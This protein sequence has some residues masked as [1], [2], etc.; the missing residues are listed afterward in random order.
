[1]ITRNIDTLYNYKQRKNNEIVIQAVRTESNKEEDRE[2]QIKA[3]W[4]N[5]TISIRDMVQGR[6]SETTE[7]FR[8]I[9]KQKRKPC[10][11]AFS[12]LIF[13][14]EGEAYACCPDISEQLYLGH[15]SMVGSIGE[16]FNSDA[17]KD[18]RKSL[19]NGIGFNKNPCKNCSSYE[20]YS[21]YKHGWRS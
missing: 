21:G 12:R 18:L 7:G 11:Q 14:H 16:I 15:I 5:A 2:G 9:D 4:P 19:K 8:S 3:R 6:N 10:L 13:N 1:M 20:S 17:A